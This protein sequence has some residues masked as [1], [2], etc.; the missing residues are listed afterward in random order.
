MSDGDGF[1]ELTIKQTRDAIVE[2][3]KDPKLAK[4]IGIEKVKLLTLKGRQ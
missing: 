1:R 2:L 4:K 3:V